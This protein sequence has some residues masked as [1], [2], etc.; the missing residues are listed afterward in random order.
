MIINW[1]IQ[2]FQ[3]LSYDMMM[4]LISNNNDPTCDSDYVLNRYRRKERVNHLQ[5]VFICILKIMLI[6]NED[7]LSVSRKNEG[8]HGIIRNISVIWNRKK[9]MNSNM[10][11]RF[12]IPFHRCVSWCEFYSLAIKRFLLLE[13]FTMFA[14]IKRI[15]QQENVWQAR[16]YWTF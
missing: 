14:N 16:I 10:M 2:N 13:I 6:S 11:Q 3:I 1:I 12:C 15:C 4:K 9:E 8:I 7:K 5:L